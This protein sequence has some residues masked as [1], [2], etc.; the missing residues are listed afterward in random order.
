LSREISPQRS[1]LTAE[2]SEKF[3]EE[4]LREC[5]YAMFRGYS[6]EEAT[7][8][9]FDEEFSHAEWHNKASDDVGVMY[10]SIMGDGFVE[11]VTLWICVRNESLLVR[12]IEWGRP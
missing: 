12:D 8:I 5:F 3:S 10:V 2:L 4:R 11:A 1:R 9:H 6:D 7:E